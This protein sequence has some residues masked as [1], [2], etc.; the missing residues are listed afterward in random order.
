MRLNPSLVTF[1]K[2]GSTNGKVTPEN[3][4]S[5]QPSP[6][7]STNIRA[8]LETLELASGSEEPRPITTRHVS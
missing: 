8:I 6:S 4:V 5:H 2:H 1:S 7:D 3:P